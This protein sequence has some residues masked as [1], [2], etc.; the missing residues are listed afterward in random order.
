M[1]LMT[2][3]EHRRSLLR[4]AAT[5]PFALALGARAAQPPKADS[6]EAQLATLE[7]SS[8]GRLGV[9]ALNTADGKQIGYRVDER[10]PFCS[11]FK[12]I[13]IGAI[14]ARSTQV[15]GLLQQRIQYSQS[16]VVHYSAVTAQHVGDGMTVGEL[17]VAAIQHSDNTAANLLIK[18]LG[19]P[20]AVTAYARLTGN[21]VFR[22]DRME[23]SLNDAVPGDPRDTATPAAMARSLQTL[24]LGEALPVQQRTQLLDWLR[25]NQMGSKRIGAALPA[26]WS[27]GDKTGTGDYGTAND[28]ALIWPPSRPPILLAIYQTQREQDA[29]ARDDVIAAAARIVLG[30]MG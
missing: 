25:G 28:L 1:T 21:P 8:G 2:C 11:T 19:G 20:Q 13:L 24:T 17:C 5:L 9:F 10:F 12:V 14:L 29:K 22:L 6:P 7:Q 23:T 3:F 18:L 30:A 27:M 16:D 26:G 15:S 4:L